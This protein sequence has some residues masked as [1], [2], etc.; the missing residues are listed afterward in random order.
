MSAKGRLLGIG[1]IVFG[2]FGENMAFAD[3]DPL[4]ANVAV[5]ILLIG[6]AKIKNG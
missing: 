4:I 1:L 2:L 6:F 5:V 3:K